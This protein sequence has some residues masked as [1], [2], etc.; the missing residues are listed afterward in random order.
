MFSFPLFKKWFLSV[1]YTH[2]NLKQSRAFWKGWCL[3][4]ILLKCEGAA[5]YHQII[6]V[7]N[8]HEPHSISELYP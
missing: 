7:I 4:M 1:C 5:F 6:H 8:I 3:K 2:G